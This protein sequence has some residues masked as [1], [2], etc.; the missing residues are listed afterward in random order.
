MMP[1]QSPTA[2][3]R[4]CQTRA[5]IPGGSQQDR[6]RDFEETMR[7][8]R[9]YLV[10]DALDRLHYVPRAREGFFSRLRQAINLLLGRGDVWVER[11][12]TRRN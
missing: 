4:L 9:P 7:H 1:R 6:E 11:R 3:L 10:K 12:Q 2:N 5:E 8:Q